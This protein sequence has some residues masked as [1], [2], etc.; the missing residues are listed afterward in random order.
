VANEEL[1]VSL[2]LRRQVI[3]RKYQAAL[4]ELYR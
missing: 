1:T 4:E 2:K 3:A